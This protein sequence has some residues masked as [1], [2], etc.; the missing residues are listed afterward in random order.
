MFIA[1]ELRRDEQ[2]KLEFMGRCIDDASEKVL[3]MWS[4]MVDTL[5]GPNFL[6]TCLDDRTIHITSV[7][8]LATNKNLHL[9]AKLPE[10]LLFMV[11][12]MKVEQFQY[13]IATQVTRAAAIHV[14][15]RLDNTLKPGQAKKVA[16]K[17]H[18]KRQQQAHKQKLEMD[19]VK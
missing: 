18:A 19:E 2:N 16:D 12:G 7:D 17:E 3:E 5:R 13:G 6:Q 1:N 10:S 8:G 9:L 4:D 11:S 15:K 14:R